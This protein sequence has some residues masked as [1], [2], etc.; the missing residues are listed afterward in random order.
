M[1]LLLMILLTESGFINTIT[2]YNEHVETRSDF[3]FV[4]CIETDVKAPEPVKFCTGNLITSNW[5]ITAAHCL[6]FENVIVSYSNAISRQLE[7]TV[8]VV[9]QIKH[10]QYRMIRNKENWS[11]V[12]DI[13]LIEV[14]RI[15]FN[16]SANLS[17]VDYEVFTKTPVAFAGFGFLR[18]QRNSNSADF[19]NIIKTIDF[20]ALFVGKGETIECN[21][22]V[23]WY[24]S[25]C[26]S[27]EQ[28]KRQIPDPGSPLS[29]NR[30][31][32]GIFSGS[33]GNKL[34]FV[35]VNLY[36]N[37]IRDVMLIEDKKQQQLRDSDKITSD[38]SNSTINIAVEI[39]F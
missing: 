30:S 12:N 11:V 6:V 25:I 34:V 1:F 5:V 32:I 10:P 7:K 23:V 26:V 37:W 28:E 20:T 36:L 39:R 22:E 14:E 31:I 38:T 17:S 2:D 27:A 21:L 29:Y 18:L 4:V 9:K 3:P 8:K 33:S 13:G 24:P 15:P 35:P 16:R 19:M